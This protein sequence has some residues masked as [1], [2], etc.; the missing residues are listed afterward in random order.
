MVS[1]SKHLTIKDVAKIQ[2]VKCLDL[3]LNIAEQQQ[4]IFERKMELL[5]RS[6]LP[7]LEVCDKLHSLSSL[8]WT[9]ESY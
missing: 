9:I 6:N 7:K 3:Q 8:I 4:T 5:E 2:Q 1:G